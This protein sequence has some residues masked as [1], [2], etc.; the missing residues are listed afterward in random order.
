MTNQNHLNLFIKH[1]LNQLQLFLQGIVDNQT[2]SNLFPKIEKRLL[3]LKNPNGERFVSAYSKLPDI[4]T[5]LFD[6][7]SPA[8]QIGTDQ[9]LSETKKEL[10]KQSL[11]GLIPWRKGPY[12]VCGITIDSEWQSNMKW[13]RLEGFL[14]E[15]QDRTVLDIGCSS[16]YY[17]YKLLSYNPKWV[18]GI[19]PSQ[20]FVFQFAALQKYAAQTKLAYFPIGLEEFDWQARGINVIFC[21]GILYHQRSPVDALKKIKSLL[22]KKGTL[23]LETMIIPGDD[24]LALFPKDRYAKMRNVYFFPTVKALTNWCYRAGFKDIEVIDISET[25]TQEQRETEWF[26]GESLVD[27]LDPKDPNQTVE[28]YPAPRRVIM[29]VQ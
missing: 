28:G 11:K 5:N 6:S 14:P 21:M 29:K 27:F 8:I 15:I 16:G 18:I 23:I 7:K 19:D 9:P 3:A 13:Q 22:A 26:T 4:K 24:D 1:Q 10:L 20:L 25:T 2:F 17:M 12:D